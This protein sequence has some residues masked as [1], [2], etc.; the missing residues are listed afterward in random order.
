MNRLL[1]L[2]LETGSACALCAIL[3]L[4]LYLALPNNNA[5]LAVY[6]RARFFFSFFLIPSK[7]CDSC[8][9]F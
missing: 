5:H 7:S 3:E 9:A 8:A 6:V 2:T 4:I 1:R